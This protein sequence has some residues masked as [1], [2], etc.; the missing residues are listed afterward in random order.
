MSNFDRKKRE[1]LIKIFAE[2]PR[3]K[4]CKMH[5]LLCEEEKFSIKFNVFLRNSAYD[6][7]FVTEKISAIWL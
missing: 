1:H 4:P 5:F 7:L 2:N 3:E 6:V